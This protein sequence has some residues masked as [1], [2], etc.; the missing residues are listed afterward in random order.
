MEK[1]VLMVVRNVYF[2]IF[3]WRNYNSPCKG[4]LSRLIN[5]FYG[6]QL[7]RIV[8]RS[9]AAIFFVCSM[10]G[11][12][13]AQQNLYSLFADKL[14]PGTTPAEATWIKGNIFLPAGAL[15]LEGSNH[16]KLFA[17][18]DNWAETAKIK[19]LK[20]GVRLPAVIYLHGC[21]GFYA[22]R[23]FV[24]YFLDQGYA[25]FAPNSFA[26]PG[27]EELCNTGNMD[28][29]IS[30][31]REELKHAL[32]KVREIDWVNASRL[33]LVGFSEGGQTVSSWGGREFMAHVLFGTDCRYVDDYSNA[34]WDIPVLNIVGES[35]EL[36]YGRGCYLTGNRP[37]SSKVVVVPDGDHAMLNSEIPR[38]ATTKFLKTC[39]GQR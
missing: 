36:G 28:D 5:T 14:P 2:L 11:V 18:K 24:T 33:V 12:V 6:L 27:R 10:A 9:I 37:N 4:P 20:D 31:R 26:R 34:P 13:M 3:A 29:R 19:H 22:G 30:L 7:G 32:S 35:D 39:C 1:K 21:T 25:V 38:L 17:K 16:L 8:I 23:R 15:K